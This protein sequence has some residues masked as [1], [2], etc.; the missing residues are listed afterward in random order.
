MLPLAQIGDALVYLQVRKFACHYL[1]CSRTS[2]A[3]NCRIRALGKGRAT[4]EVTSLELL[5]R[6]M[7]SVIGKCDDAPVSSKAI[8]IE[9]SKT[10]TLGLPQGSDGCARDVLFLAFADSWTR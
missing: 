10:V 1:V 5:E 7:L 3:L 4:L 2:L 6:A 8:R 9:R